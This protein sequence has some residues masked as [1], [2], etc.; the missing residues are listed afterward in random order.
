MK[1]RRPCD[2]GCGT[3]GR[4]TRRHFLFGT[5]GL[6]SAALLRTPSDAALYAAGVTTRKTA[7]TCIF[8][9]LNGGPSHVDTFD[10]KDGAWN[11]RDADI[12]Q[13]PGD[14][15]LSR[16]YFPMLS[17]MTADLCILRSVSSWEANHQRGQFYVQT[18]HSF[19]PAL[20]ASM[21]HIGAVLAYELGDSKK[22]LPPFISLA[23]PQD[24]QQQGFLAGATTPFTLV[25]QS[26]G[27]SNLR[28]DFYGDESKA[29]FDN[30][31]AMLQDLDAPLRS[32]PW[33]AYVAA[34]SAIV[35]QARSMIYNDAIGK[36]FQY[37]NAD[38]GRYGATTFAQS[39]LVARNIVQAN[40][41]TV[42]IST[43]QTGWDTH[44]QQ[45][46]S[47]K[48]TTIYSLTSELDRALS[49]LIADLRLSGDLSRTLIVV[50]GEFGRT[51]GPLNF[52][53]GRDHFRN[54]M[55]ALLIG[56]GVRGG[57]AI[58]KTDAT[59]S[60]IV[61]PGWSAGRPIY[62]EDIVATIYS[63]MGVDWTKSIENTP[64]GRRYI[65][66]TGAETGQFGPIDEVFI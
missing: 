61:D 19:N 4:L 44:A 15:V 57:R 56:G 7:R 6:T 21:P 53:D 30:S 31:Y 11:P 32:Q 10:P 14:I 50:M 62:V 35:N 17:A 3:H 60:A 47:K 65:Y 20:A 24:E 29:F 51:P 28:H 39:L 55:S 46:D 64:F 66:V 27:L 59:G 36:V 23:P 33:D 25:P 26:G 9:N 1:H 34:Y 48:G 49:N 37:S 42:F 18:A 43:S 45:F 41:G 5:L 8:I 12:R 40:L 38:A 22:P 16:R 52:R 58:G 63:A 54:V 2:S 13:Y